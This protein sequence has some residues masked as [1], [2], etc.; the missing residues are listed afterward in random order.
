[1]R[2][3]VGRRI[4]PSPLTLVGWQGWGLPGPERLVKTAKGQNRAYAN[5]QLLTLKHRPI[6]MRQMVR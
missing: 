4:P 6:H 5:L 2:C 3:T 1:M